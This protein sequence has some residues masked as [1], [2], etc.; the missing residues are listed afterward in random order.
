MTQRRHKQERLA[1]LVSELGAD[2]ARRDQFG[3]RTVNPQRD[4]Q[5]ARARATLTRAEAKEL[6]NLS[7]RDAAR[8]VEANRAMVEQERAAAADRARRLRAEP[9]HDAHRCGPHRDGPALG[10]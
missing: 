5:D 9:T 4:A 10:R 7:A 1:L 3:M 2:E 6:R 8:R